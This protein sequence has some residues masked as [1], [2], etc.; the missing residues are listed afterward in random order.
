MNLTMRLRYLSHMRKSS[1]NAHSDVASVDS[2]LKFGL[3]FRLHSY[4]V[5]ASS[6]ALSS[7]RT[8]RRLD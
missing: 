8:L 1:L 4:A 5:C 7:L 6:E 2:D 3:S